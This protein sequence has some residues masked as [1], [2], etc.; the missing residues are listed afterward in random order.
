MD[1]VSLVTSKVH[2]E[3]WN[4]KMKKMSNLMEDILDYVKIVS[5]QVQVE[6]IGKYVRVVAKTR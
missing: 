3:I 5:M 1:V 2:S 4:L 6:S